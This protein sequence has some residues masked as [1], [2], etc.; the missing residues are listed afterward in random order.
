MAVVVGSGLKCRVIWPCL[1]LEDA[2]VID[3]FDRITIDPRKMNGQ[4]CIRGMRLT[5]RR[6]LEALSAA[7]SRDELRA[8]YPEV[9]DEDLRKYSE[10]GREQLRRPNQSVGPGDSCT[11]S[12]SH[13]RFDRLLSSD[14]LLAAHARGQSDGEEGDCA[15]SCAYQGL[16]RVRIKTSRVSA[17]PIP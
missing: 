6:V 17:R 3:T 16:C 10:L 5:V 8:D 11:S 13:G 7:G 14:R 9:E 15:C 1:L 2:E 12:P 4:P